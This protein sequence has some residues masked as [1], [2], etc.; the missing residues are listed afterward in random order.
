MKKLKLFL[1]S[2]LISISFVAA[3]CGV[4]ILPKT[5]Q[6]GVI[7]QRHNSISKE[8][9][10]IK[11]TARTM[12]W[13]HDPSFV[14]EYFTPI[15]FLIKNEKGHKVTVSYKEFIM[16]DDMGN[17]YNAIPPEK[18][19]EILLAREY[20]P[21]Y[22]YYPYYPYTETVIIREKEGT[23]T[24][25]G[26]GV[27]LFYYYRRSFSNIS[28][29]ALP[30]GDIHPNAQVRGFVYFAKADKHGNELKIKIKID[31]VEQ[32]FEFILQR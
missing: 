3:G 20:Y 29:Y 17:Q 32:E 11:I 7:D 4:K 28:L 6:E 31:G 25:F 16:F 10:G 24:T 22:P 2:I 19:N 12:E 21:F 18:V 1:L 30:E 9:D 13:Y 8:K 15:F 26:F 27:P 5:L 23:Y 14:D